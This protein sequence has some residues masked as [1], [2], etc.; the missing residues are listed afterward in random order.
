L[1]GEDKAKIRMSL[2][3]A[4]LE[5]LLRSRKLDRTLTSS[6]PPLH[7]R[8]EAGHSPEGSVKDKPK[9]NHQGEHHQRENNQRE[10]TQRENTQRENSQRENSHRENSHRE[11]SHRENN[12]EYDFAP[13]GV[14]ALDARLG[15]G[16]PRGQLS[17]L[18]GPRSSGRTSLLLR[19]LAAATARGELVAVVDAL[20]VFDVDSAAAAGVDLPRLLWVRGHAV[21]NPGLCRD[22]NARALDQ[23]VKALSLVLS[24][25]NFGLVALDV[26][27]VPRDAIRRLPFTTWLRLQRI[28]EGS[29]TTCVL[30]GAE[31]MARS[32]AGLTLQL[33]PRP[34]L[35][36]GGRRFRGRLFEG[37][38]LEVRVVRARWHERISGNS[39]N[40]GNSGNSGNGGQCGEPP[41]R[42]DD[43]RVSLSTSAR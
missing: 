12:D 7:P 23:A 42:L 3:R 33:G 36:I 25:G 6:L 1:Q 28:I 5:S 30:T 20:D 29:H 32:S 37:L 21:S 15:G 18:V 26:A 16:F 43:V 9:E 35:G 4:N 41:R 27:D 8:G 19:M 24:A 38:D 22:L 31:P 13:T 2:A 14:T 34:A 10:N 40:S 11:N 39:A 17:E